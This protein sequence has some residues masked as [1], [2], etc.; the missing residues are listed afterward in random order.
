MTTELTIPT[1]RDCLFKVKPKMLDRN[2]NYCILRMIQVF[3]R[4]AE[5]DT[6]TKYLDALNKFIRM[7]LPDDVDFND[8][9]DRKTIK[10][11]IRHNWICAIL[12]QRPTHC[13]IIFWVNSFEE[14]WQYC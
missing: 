5:D 12:E 11:W 10:Y 8:N 9:R 2:N 4:G 13:E 1:M 7:E 6:L 14:S 3:A